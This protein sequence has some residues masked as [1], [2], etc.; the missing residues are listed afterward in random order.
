LAYQQQLT[1]QFTKP[2]PS[3]G[4]Q[5]SKYILVYKGQISANPAEPDPDDP[6]SIAVCIFA[7]PT[8]P[9]QITNITPPMGCPDS[10][11][12][13]EG[14][15]FSKVPAENLISFVDVNGYYPPVYA[16][17]LDADVN[18]TR[19]TVELPYF[20][21]ENVDYYWTQVQVAID[22]NISDPFYFK[23]T[24]YVW[25]TI[26]I[27]DGGTTIDDEFDIYINGE[28]WF[29]CPPVNFNNRRSVYCGFYYA[30]EYSYLDVYLYDSQVEGGTLG[31]T[32]YPY[33]TRIRAYRWNSNEEQQ[34]FLFDNLYD[35][36]FLHNFNSDTLVIPNDG[37]EMDVYTAATYNGS[38]DLVPT[39]I[40]IVEDAD[41]FNSGEHLDRLEPVR[42][43]QT[44]QDSA[45]LSRRAR[46]IT[47]R[48][49]N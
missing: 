35:G 11:L 6:E 33:I 17:V 3:A 21:A 38:T 14:T 27:W 36:F 5:I 40:N 4:H 41:S 15:G 22:S 13:I 29:T 1:G 9:M 46:R 42:I 43:Y 24:N 30:D 47:E 49:K 18:G 34:E 19:L 16:T 23:L 44:K 8:V 7:P 28:Y 12:L 25:C 48:L 2:N 32:V 37:V 20:N 39:S 26:T 31:I 45:I 10:V